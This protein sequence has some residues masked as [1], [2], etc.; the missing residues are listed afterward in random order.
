MNLIVRIPEEY[1]AR[2]SGVDSE[3]LERAA[4]EAVLR[5]TEDGA[6]GQRALA[7]IASDLSP[8]EAAARML[9]ARPGNPLPSDITIRDLMT[10]GRA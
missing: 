10:H 7:D 1:A 2:V 3:R 6:R 9:A 5:V 8:N 4:L